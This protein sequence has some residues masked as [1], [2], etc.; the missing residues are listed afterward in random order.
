M[1]QNDVKRINVQLDC[2]LSSHMY[3]FNPSTPTSLCQRSNQ[4]DLGEKEQ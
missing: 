1:V 2:L 3:S 4:E